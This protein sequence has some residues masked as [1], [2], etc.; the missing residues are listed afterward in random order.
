[1]T[2]LEETHSTSVDDV[3][4][5]D[6]EIL[7]KVLK[8][9]LEAIP[10]SPSE[11][12]A[13]LADLDRDLGHHMKWEEEDLFPAVRERANQDQKRSIESLEIDHERIRETLK[14]LREA[15]VADDRARATELSNLLHT[16]L[17]GHNYDE[18]HGVYVDADRLLTPIERSR[19]LG[20]FRSRQGKACA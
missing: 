20:S 5:D 3:L 2:K 7:G 12:S 10:E 18:E 9:L 19:L 13:I 14:G 16:Y 4:G 8:R 17:R 11:A 1:M 6:H 15:L